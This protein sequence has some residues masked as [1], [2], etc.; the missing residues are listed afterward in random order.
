MQRVS[1]FETDATQNG[2]FCAKRAI[3]LILITG[4]LKANAFAGSPAKVEFTGDVHTTARAGYAGKSFVL[5]DANSTDR[6]LWGLYGKETSWTS[7][8]PC[9][10]QVKNESVNDQKVKGTF[11]KQCAARKKLKTTHW[12]APTLQT[13]ISVVPEPLSPG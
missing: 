1:R 12:K 5:G 11:T 13:P 7:N 8:V 3:M 4:M 2:L 9:W 6:A 10:V